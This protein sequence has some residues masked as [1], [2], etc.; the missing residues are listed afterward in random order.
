MLRSRG[1]CWPTPSFGR[2]CML[3]W[4]RYPYAWKRPQY[5]VLW[6]RT[7]VK[8][9]YSVFLVSIR[10]SAHSLPSRR[11]QE[12]LMA[13]PIEYGRLIVAM[14][15]ATAAG[16]VKWTASIDE[17]SVKL[18]DALITLRSGIEL[19]LQQAFVEFALRDAN[20]TLIDAWSVDHYD[21]DFKIKAHPT[22]QT[23]SVRSRRSSITPPPSA[24]PATQQLLLPAATARSP[25]SAP[26]R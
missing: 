2:A 22:F 11:N 23:S 6:N 14:S 7:N 15:A 18:P 20:G 5:R 12:F 17:Y 10:Q 9:W 3:K 4:R 8:H 19:P 24:T 16:R 25:V 21:P 1:A 13:M 26:R